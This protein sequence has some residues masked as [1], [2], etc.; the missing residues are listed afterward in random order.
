[1]SGG[2]A[3]A[4]VLNQW[5]G[6][7][8]WLRAVPSGAGE[9]RS[10]N[11]MVT[12][13]ISRGTQLTTLYTKLL[14]LACSSEYAPPYPETRVV[15]T[16]RVPVYTAIHYDVLAWSQM[17]DSAASL[18]LQI[19]G[20]PMTRAGIE[21]GATSVM[22]VGDGAVPAT[23]P[24]TGASI[25]AALQAML[26]RYPETIR[27]FYE[28]RANLSAMLL[29]SGSVYLP[30]DSIP[31]MGIAAGGLQ[32]DWGGLTVTEDSMHD[33]VVATYIQA[34]AVGG[35]KQHVADVFQES[36]PY[37]PGETVRSDLANRWAAAG[38]FQGCGAMLPEA[39]STFSSSRDVPFRGAMDGVAGSRLLAAYCGATK[40]GIIEMLAQGI[41]LKRVNQAGNT[42]NIAAA[43][44]TWARQLHLLTA[45]DESVGTEF[46]TQQ[47]VLKDKVRRAS[48]ASIEVGEPLVDGAGSVEY[49]AV[50]Y[51]KL[52]ELQC[53]EWKMTAQPM[54]PE[55][56][57]HVRYFDVEQRARPPTGHSGS[58]RGTR[59]NGQTQLYRDNTGGLAA[60]LPPVAGRR[61]TISPPPVENNTSALSAG[62]LMLD[63]RAGEDVP[64]EAGNSRNVTRPLI[65]EPSGVALT[66]VTELIQDAARTGEMRADIVL[67]RLLEGAGPITR[68]VIEK[69]GQTIGTVS[70]EEFKTYEMHIKQRRAEKGTSTGAV[71]AAAK[72]TY[73]QR[74]GEACGHD[75]LRSLAMYSG[76]DE[77]DPKSLIEGGQHMLMGSGMLEV[78]EEARPWATTNELASAF[79]YKGYQSLEQTN[80]VSGETVRQAARDGDVMIL[81]TG[82]HWVMLVADAFG[83]AVLH[84]NQH[85]PRRLIG[86]AFELMVNNAVHLG[87][88]DHLC[89]M[90][91]IS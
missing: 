58:Q 27:Q 29:G 25:A 23:P 82:A 46:H 3:Q 33:I 73:Q 38:A 67:D 57:E 19:M 14:L 18:A 60:S 71:P 34:G 48:F 17:I 47:T 81:N 37:W 2:Q 86:S 28:A 9:Q 42:V 24:I 78:P 69:G 12:M 72:I 43:G 22:V 62:H 15:T 45:P 16:A 88:T 8:V 49:P 91:R 26:R 5:S 40:G 1:M 13:R 50:G 63:S 74:P 64:G 76:W 56:F 89:H 90:R 54:A 52:R 32:A 35:T 51:V 36:R 85:E 77:T 21:I 39:A 84:E 53:K 68:Y 6:L 79:M 66:P 41:Q 87:A 30:P 4:N 31:L 83:G 65:M 7:A 11:A 44:R 70:P 59:P 75:A 61:R 55:D 20:M 80:S 10:F